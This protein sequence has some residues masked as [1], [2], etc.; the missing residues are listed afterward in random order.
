MKDKI[1]AIFDDDTL[2]EEAK[3]TALLESTKDFVPKARLTEYADKLRTAEKERDDVNTELKTIKD[4]SMTAEQKA[5]ADMDKFKQDQLLLSKKLNEVDVRTLFTGAGL[6][7]AKI[8]ELVEKVVSDD[9][10]KSIALANSFVAIFNDVKENTKKTTTTDLLRN[11]PA[12][13]VSNS[14][15]KEISKD[16]FKNMAYGDKKQLFAE[17]PEQFKKLSE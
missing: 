7:Q 8:D 1:N 3:K 12:P 2:D 15:P 16:D 17:N 14:T 11:T 5:K 4:A 6:E 9:H 13:V 10:D